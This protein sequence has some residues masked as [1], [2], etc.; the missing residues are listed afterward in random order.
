MNPPADP[1]E[2]VSTSDVPDRP[3]LVRRLYDEITDKVAV[4][5]PW[6]RLPKIAGLAELIGIRDT[7]RQKNLVDT[8]RLPAVDPV[9]PPPE[10]PAGPAPP[11]PARPTPL[12][13]P[14]GG[15]EGPA[16]GA[17]GGTQQDSDNDVVD[18]EIVD[19][20]PEDTREGGAA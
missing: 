17:D 1:P 12:P 2:G 10:H 11:T 9:P 20:G 7:L 8:S 16:A 6:Y 15:A 14:P 18:A 4:R 19:E 3:G 13:P 5:H